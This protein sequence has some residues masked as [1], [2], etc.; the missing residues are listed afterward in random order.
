MI[1]G[2]LEVNTQYRWRGKWWKT[3]ISLA[4]KISRHTIFSTRLLLCGYWTKKK[5]CT[6]PKCWTWKSIT[7]MQ[8]LLS[9]RM[10]QKGMQF[11]SIMKSHNLQK[12]VALHLAKW[13]I[14]SL[15]FNLFVECFIWDVCHSG[16]PSMQVLAYS[17]PSIRFCFGIMRSFIAY[18]Y[19]LAICVEYLFDYAL[20]PI[21]KNLTSRDNN[22]PRYKQH[23]RLFCFGYLQWQVFYNSGVCVSTKDAWN[24]SR[25]PWGFILGNI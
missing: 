25:W 7:K 19:A 13:N 6:C 2:L 18:A 5:W 15:T 20:R 3:Q 1:L 10:S 16:G 8:G 14:S 11:G 22:V 4:R 12:W 21:K 23:Q 24:D 17:C 9:S